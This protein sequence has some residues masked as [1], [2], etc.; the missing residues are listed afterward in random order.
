MTPRVSKY[1][2]AADR[3]KRYGGGHQRLRR[4]LGPIVA[5]G[6]VRCARGADCKFA[7][8]GVGGFIHPGEEWDLGHDDYNSGRYSGPEHAVCNRATFSRRRRVSRDW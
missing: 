1:L 2:P 8:G 7:D 4:A 6:T 5:S 3:R